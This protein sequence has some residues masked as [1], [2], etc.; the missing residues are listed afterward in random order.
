MA[1][2]NYRCCCVIQR[3]GSYNRFSHK[4]YRDANIITAVDTLTSLLAGC[5]IFAALGNLAFVLNQ[6]IDKVVS[7]GM[8]LAFKAYPLILSKIGWA[9]Q[10]CHFFVH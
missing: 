9:P 7:K 2:L 3:L 6:P 5:T 4:L 8:S 10:V 1:C